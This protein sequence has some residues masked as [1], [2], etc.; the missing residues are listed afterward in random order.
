MAQND[1][2]NAEDAPPAANYPPQNNQNQPFPA[3]ANFSEP[4]YSSSNT[5]CPNPAN[6]FHPGSNPSPATT[7]TVDPD[8]PTPKTAWRT[9][10]TVISAIA[11]VG[12]PFL[13]MTLRTLQGTVGWATLI[14]MLTVFPMLVVMNVVFLILSRKLPV[15]FP[16]TKFWNPA[17]LSAGYYL[18]WFWGTLGLVFVPDGGDEGENMIPLALKALNPAIASSAGMTIASLL[19]FLALSAFI[20]AV[21]VGLLAKSKFS[22]PANPQY[23]PLQQDPKWGNY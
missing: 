14:M 22:V 3:S 23:P 6:Q 10:L 15:G 13:V 2:L 4:T 11:I 20:Y 8:L 16:Q 5:Q 17:N 1:P 19:E 21:V 7:L 18:A 9:T 12:M